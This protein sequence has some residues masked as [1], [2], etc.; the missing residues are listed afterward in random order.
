M[1]NPLATN[2]RA[3]RVRAVRA[4]M[5]EYPS[6]LR[7]RSVSYSIRVVAMR[8][9]SD[10]SVGSRFMTVDSNH[11]A[12]RTIGSTVE[13]VANTTAALELAARYSID[14]PTARAVDLALREEL[15]GEHAA[16]Q[17]RRLFEAALHPATDDG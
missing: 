8:T 3:A 16:E 13:G 10:G 17:L 2:H 4:G 9:G 6:S 1:T 14:L 7:T 5:L 12:L 11:S 15:T